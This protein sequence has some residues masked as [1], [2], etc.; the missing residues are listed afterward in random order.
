MIYWYEIQVYQHRRILTSSAPACTNRRAPLASE[1]VRSTRRSCQDSSS[2]AY[3]RSFARRGAPLATFDT[4]VYCPDAGLGRSPAD[5]Q[6]L[7]ACP[8]LMQ[9]LWLIPCRSL[10][11]FFRKCCR[12]PLSSAGSTVDPQPFDR[13]MLTSSAPAC[14]NRRAPLASEM[15]RST[16]RSCRHSSSPACTRSFARL[17]SS[18]AIT[19]VIGHLDW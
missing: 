8:V 10:A 17:G 15:F 12:L 4:T 1:L 19:A 9:V 5:T 11:G 16:W 7:V 14:T 18:L 13:T 2:P 6:R 3:T